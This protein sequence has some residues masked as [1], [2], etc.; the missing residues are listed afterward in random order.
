[1]RFERP[2]YWKQQFRRRQFR[3]SEVGIQQDLPEVSEAGYS[4][5]QIWQINL[6]APN[7]QG[8]IFAQPGRKRAHG[9]CAEA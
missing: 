3:Y 4:R 2:L 9:V 6:V 8:R 1:M 5:L 7:L